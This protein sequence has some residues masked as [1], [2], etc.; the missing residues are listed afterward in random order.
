MMSPG[1]LSDVYGS[2]MINAAIDYAV[3]LSEMAEGRVD[4][5]EYKNRL[6]IKKQGIHLLS[7]GIKF[8]PAEVLR[9]NGNSADSS[10]QAEVTGF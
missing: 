4:L 7:S 6:A 8:E 5:S 3:G 2:Q 9:F 10:S 1:E